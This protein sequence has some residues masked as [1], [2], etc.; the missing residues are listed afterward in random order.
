MGAL[1]TKLRTLQGGRVAFHCPGCDCAHQ[2]T[3]EGGF[4]NAWGFNGNGDAPTFTP[5]VLVTG[6]RRITDDEHARI[7]AGETIDLPDTICHSFVTDGN[8]QFLADCTHVLAGQTVPL[9]DFET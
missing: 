9:P 4:A 1:G 2:V 7:M 6:K 5:S 3:V 8:I